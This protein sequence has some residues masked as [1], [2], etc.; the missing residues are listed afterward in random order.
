M[1]TMFL[2]RNSKRKVKKRIIRNENN[3]YSSTSLSVK[4]LFSLLF[5]FIRSNFTL[6]FTPYPLDQRNVTVKESSYLI[7]ILY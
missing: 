1:T 4:F 6:F 5:P 7:Q 2:L 3:K